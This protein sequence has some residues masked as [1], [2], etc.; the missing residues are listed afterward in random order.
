MCV[1]FGIGVR[2]SEGFLIFGERY[3]ARRA[4]WGERLNLIQLLTM[5]GLAISAP[6]EATT[7]LEEACLFYTAQVDDVAKDTYRAA[8]QIESRKVGVSLNWERVHS[9]DEC[10]AGRPLLVVSEG[11]V[12]QLSLAGDVHGTI[13]LERV[14]KESRARTLASS[15]LGRILSEREA[16]RLPLLGAGEITLGKNES[17]VITIAGL[18][19]DLPVKP[20]MGLGGFVRAGGGY[21]LLAQR[22]PMSAV[23]LNLGLTLFEERMALGLSGMFGWGRWVTQENRRTTDAQIIELMTSIR[24]GRA[25]GD[26]VVRGGAG[27]GLRLHRT[28]SQWEGEDKE[29]RPD[30]EDWED[31]WIGGLVELQGE[32]QWKMTKR[33]HLAML[34]A[35]RVSWQEEGR[36]FYP[37]FRGLLSLG[38]SL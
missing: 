15:V 3:D 34:I 36:D 6:A 14:A 4:Q 30:E 26:W 7:P 35:P 8:L 29:D 11:P 20:D 31:R 23:S 33:V 22:K 2:G 37:G 16:S 19:A 38:V 32:V 18:D 17:S 12:A 25:F 27:V 24:G 13:N 10:G 21:L 9:T 1:L 28:Q 5:I